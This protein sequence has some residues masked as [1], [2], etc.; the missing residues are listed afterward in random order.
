MKDVEP[1]A[2]ICQIN[3]YI[4]ARIDQFQLFFPDKIIYHEYRRWIGSL[5]ELN[6]NER[7]SWIGI[8]TGT[9]NILS[10]RHPFY[11]AEA[12]KGGK[13][14]EYNEEYSHEVNAEPKLGQFIKKE[15]NFRK[16]LT[17]T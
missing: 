2:K 5:L 4:G 17:L 3:V 6:L 11:L 9:L 8:D 1:P 16:A 13:E 12:N 15:P 7:S 10:Q 14:K